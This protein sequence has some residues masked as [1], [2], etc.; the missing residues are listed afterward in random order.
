VTVLAFHTILHPT[1]FS[2]NSMHALRLAGELARDYQA[3]LIVLHVVATPGISSGDET[4]PLDP[5]L[6]LRDARDNLNR[7]DVPGMLLERRLEEGEPAAEILRVAQDSGA[8]LIVMGTHGR[9]GLVRLLMGSVADQVIRQSTCP[10][11]TVPENLTEPIK[12]SMAFDV[13]DEASEES[14]PASDP[15]AWIGRGR[16]WNRRFPCSP[17]Q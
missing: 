2:D 12:A 3:R 10:V 4:L 5:E 1:D 13:V 14:F 7:V 6:F 17:Q 15:P 16:P 9:T 8:S 11:M